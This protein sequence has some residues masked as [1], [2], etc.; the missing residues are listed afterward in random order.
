MIPG[1]PDNLNNVNV[2]YSFTLKYDFLSNFYPV[3]VLY[4]GAV[5]PSVE[6]AYQAAKTT[7]PELRIPFQG[8]AIRSNLM[9]AGQAKRAGRKLGLRGNWDP[10][11]IA[12][13]E[14][15]L[16]QKFENPHLRKKLLRTGSAFLIEGNNWND[17]TWGAVFNPNTRDWE[18]RNLLGSLLMQIREDIRN[19]E[20]NTDAE[21]PDSV[22]ED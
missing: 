5:Y 15:L 13:M 8:S 21:I 19:E 17:R 16:R 12:I 4:E 2:I 22:Q 6:H 18:G 1:N 10:V 20:T 3:D 11:K 9:S 14:T 7:D